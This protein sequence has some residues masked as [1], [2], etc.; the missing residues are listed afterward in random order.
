MSEQYLSQ[1][2]IDALLDAPEGAGAD[3]PA[4]AD[5]DTAATGDGDAAAAAPLP[6]TTVAD[7]GSTPSK[8]KAPSW[9]GR[10][11]TA[12]ARVRSC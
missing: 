7:R 5:A 2:E 11:I 6:A 1:E 8:Q 10:T 9:P 12:A 4:S 3:A